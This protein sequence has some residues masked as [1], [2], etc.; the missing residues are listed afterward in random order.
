MN[1][2]QIFKTLISTKMKIGEKKFRKQ[3]MQNDPEDTE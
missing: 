2:M 3:S 1:K